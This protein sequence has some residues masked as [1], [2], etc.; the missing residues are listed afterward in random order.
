MAGAREQR[1][2]KAIGEFDELTVI[3]WDT[4]MPQTGMSRRHTEHFRITRDF[5]ANPQ[6][7]LRH[8]MSPD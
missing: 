1:S 3:C 8:L 5:L 4:Q 2:R 7:M 6:R